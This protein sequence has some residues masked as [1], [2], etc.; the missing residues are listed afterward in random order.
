MLA[1]QRMSERI[2]Q[3]G[4]KKAL[5][6]SKLLLL[7]RHHH[8]LEFLVPSWSCESH[9]FVVACWEFTPTFKDVAR[10]TMLPMFGEAN[11]MELSWRRY[12]TSAMTASK[13]SCKATYATWL[14]FFDEGD[15]NRITYVD[16][17][18]LA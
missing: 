6:C 14:R 4:V 15:D 11:A 5:S 1:L 8:D 18:F 12:L 13:T 7:T 9:S 16:E 2:Y 17:A 10:L 3:V